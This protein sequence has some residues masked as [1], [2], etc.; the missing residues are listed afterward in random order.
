MVINP[1]Q[2]NNL[3][4]SF[5]SSTTFGGL[6]TIRKMEYLIKMHYSLHQTEILKRNKN[7]FIKIT[8]H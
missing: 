8:H 2:K 6:E 5:R 7:F 1:P 4:A 3:R